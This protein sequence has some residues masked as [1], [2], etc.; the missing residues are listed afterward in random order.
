M[1]KGVADAGDRSF[2]GTTPEDADMGSAMVF[3]GVFTVMSEAEALLIICTHE[4]RRMTL[5]PSWQRSGW[6][7]MPLVLSQPY[8]IFDLL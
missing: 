7:A 1:M 3:A 6:M 2:T 5:L 8:S 4:L